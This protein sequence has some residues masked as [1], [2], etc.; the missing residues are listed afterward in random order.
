MKMTFQFE[1]PD[2][3][4]YQDR[5]RAM[6]IFFD[7]Y[8]GRSC[9]RY[10]DITIDTLP[11]YIIYLLKGYQDQ[12]YT[13]G[14][15]GDLAHD[16]RVQILRRRLQEFPDETYPEYSYDE[17]ISVPLTILGYMDGFGIQYEMLP[18]DVPF[19][20][21]ILTRTDLIPQEKNQRIFDHQDTCDYEERY[22]ANSARGLA[23]KDSQL[24]K[25]LNP[26]P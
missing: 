17:S 11:L 1:V 23:K 12:E 26:E 25:L 14:I 16:L 9:K 7:H 24:I 21:N 2:D 6:N 4:D 13:Y 22:K 3:D 5:M 18:E 19:F 20:I 10:Q 8:I 15:L